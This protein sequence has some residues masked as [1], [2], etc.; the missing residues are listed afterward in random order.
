MIPAT[1]LNAHSVVPGIGLPV[2]GFFFGLGILLGIVYI[3]VYGE[4]KHGLPR[5]RILHWL[6]ISTVTTLAF[7]HWVELL[8]YRPELSFFEGG[9]WLRFFDGIASTGA[10]A[11]ALLGSA[12]FVVLFRAP[13]ASYYAV[14]FEGCALVWGIGR[15]GCALLN[16]HL[17][18]PTTFFLGVRFPDGSVRHDLGLYECVY[19]LSVLTPYVWRRRNAPA[20]PVGMIS[21]ISLA[22]GAFRFLID[23]LRPE[24]RYAGLTFAQYFSLFLV[25]LGGGLLLWRRRKNMKPL[26]SLQIGFDRFAKIRSRP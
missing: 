4:K 17:A 20:D 14:G 5:H 8:F 19:L 1:T 21:A 23:F 24:V 13:I 22:Y 15:I 16:E 11:G 7:A 2:F 12:I 25:A 6:A 18:G 3:V 9:R 10:M 26:A